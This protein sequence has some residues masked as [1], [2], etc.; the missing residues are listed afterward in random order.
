MIAFS[1]EQGHGIYSGLV[2]ARKISDF[3]FDPLVFFP[4]LV[5]IYIYALSWFAFQISQGKRGIVSLFSYIVVS[6]MVLF[7][8]KTK[9]PIEVKYYLLYLKE[10]GN[11][12]T[13]QVTS[14][15]GYTDEIMVYKG[16]IAPASVET[17]KVSSVP[18][19]VDMFSLLDPLIE[20]VYRAGFFLDKWDV[21]NL[22]RAVCLNPENLFNR[23]LSYPFQVIL[24]ELASSGMTS[25][26]ANYISGIGKTL[27]EVKSGEDIWDEIST[28]NPNSFWDRIMSSPIAICGTDLVFN[29]DDWFWYV[30]SY[31]LE[32][33]LSICEGEFASAGYNKLNMKKAVEEFVVKY[34]KNTV[35]N[36]LKVI[37]PNVSN[38]TERIEASGMGGSGAIG[39]LDFV[40]D[41]VLKI[42]SFMNKNFSYH[43]AT[44]FKLLHETQGTVLSIIIG[45]SP[46]VFLFSLVPVGDSMI[47][48]KLI[49]T[50]FFAYFLVYLWVP[51]LYIIFLIVWG[52][53]TTGVMFMS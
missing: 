27:K 10:G 14:T 18:Y 13:K 40:Q 9:G 25:C 5:L 47:N 34:G 41:L 32:E 7:L 39:F 43:F 42:S 1:V 45:F 2:L 48:V 8:I 24:D 50:Y 46:L 28:K 3:I 35:D 49:A 16:T 44:K 22:D 20:G 4:L 53:A 38:L 33:Q 21:R 26:L 30:V 6:S 31:G 37:Y 11:Y 17:V 51:V 23:A 29:V 15:G 52:I 19:I 12:A 36:M